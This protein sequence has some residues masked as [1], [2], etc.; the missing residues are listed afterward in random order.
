M[1]VSYFIKMTILW[2]KVAL[3]YLA[4][5]LTGGIPFG[6]I[7]ARMKGVDLRKIGSGNIG[8]TNVYRALGMK[9]AAL[10]F[11]LDLL[12]GALCALAGLWLFHAGTEAALSGMAAVLGHIFSPFLKFKGGKGVATALGVMLVFAPIPSLI[13]FAVW[14]MIAFWKRVVSA[15]SIIAALLL[16]ALVY[17]FYKTGWEFYISLAVV[18]VVILSHWENMVRLVRGDEKPVRRISG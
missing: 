18:G 15:A 16:P 17:L 1:A 10:V 12:K 9:F 7:V 5:F 8:S 6:P 14:V 4:F 3:A 2:L 13:S 11:A